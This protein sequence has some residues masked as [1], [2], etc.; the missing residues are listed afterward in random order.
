MSSK[1]HSAGVALGVAHR[2]RRLARLQDDDLAGLHV[3]DVL[4]A[5]DVEAG[6]LRR[7]APAGRASSSRP[8]AGVRAAGRRRRG[9]RPRT[10]GRNP[11]GSRTP[12]TRRL[13]RMTRLNAPRTRGSTWTQRLDRVRGRLVGEQRGQQLGVGRGGQP[14]AAALELGQQLP[15]VDEVAVVPDRDRPPRPQPDRS[16]GRSPRSSS[17]SSSS[18]SGRWPG[19][20]AGSAAAAR[21][22]PCAIIPRS[23]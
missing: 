4:G 3:A 17:R 11:C 6:R 20:R 5:D 1:T 7:E 12:M 23:L 8:Q 19:R 21:R 10:S 2:A 16:A 22:G 15:R 18:G 9:S 13:S 14:G